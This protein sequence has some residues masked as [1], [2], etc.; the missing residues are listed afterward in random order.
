[1]VENLSV[2][3]PGKDFRVKIE[4]LQDLA[5][6]VGKISQFLPREVIW[7]LYSSS[8]EQT[9]GKIVFPYCRIDSASRNAAFDVDYLR[10]YRNSLT[11][12]KFKEIY[13]SASLQ[14][15]KA[16][17]WVGIGFQGLE[18]LAESKASSNWPRSTKNLDRFVAMRE[19]Y[20]AKLRLFTAF[21]EEEGIYN[22]I[23]SEYGLEDLLNE[24]K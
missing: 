8:P 16:L 13:N 19:L 20:R 4:V 9:G 2:Y 5:P 23:F 14:A 12:E 18:N 3:I 1:M 24:F 10:D 22:D 17:V 15:F 6:V 21:R 7:D 11:D